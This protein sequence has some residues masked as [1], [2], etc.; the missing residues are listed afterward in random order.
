MGPYKKYWFTLIG[1]CIVMF[2]LLGYFGAEVYRSAPPI[3]AQVSTADGEPL[4]TRDDILDGQTAWQSVGGMQ[5]GS[6]WGHGA[7]QA[8]D[9]TAD[10]LHRELTA[11]LELAAQ[12]LH[13]RPYAQLE[14]GAQGALR[15]ELAAEYR[16]NGPGA[17]ETLVVSARRAQAMTQTA[18]YYDQLFSDAPALRKSRESFAMKENTLPDAERRAAM[19]HF[20]FWT[21]WAAATERPGSQVTYTNNWP[22]EPLIGNV[23]SGENIVWSIASVAILLAGIGLLVWGWAFLRDHEAPL[24]AAPARDPLTRFPL[25]PSQRALGKYLFLVVALFVFQVFI[26]GFTA[27]YTVERSFYGLDLSQWFPYALTR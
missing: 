14:A 9:W 22:H 7:Y 3:P 13:G 18:A 11:W 5:L 4:F 27:H 12:E 26:G 1:V 24:P 2:S 19:T 23:P 21:A 6:I 16:G 20:F 8:P 25:T 15:A 17:N 10:W